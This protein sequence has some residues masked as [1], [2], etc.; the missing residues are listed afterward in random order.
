VDV[1]T[2]HPSGSYKIVGDKVKEKL[3][4]TD[5]KA[6]WSVSKYLVVVVD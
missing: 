1:L 5:Q 6:F 4:I 2:T 3:V